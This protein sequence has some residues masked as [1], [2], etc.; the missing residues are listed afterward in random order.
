MWQYS[1]VIST[2]CPAFVQKDPH[3]LGFHDHLAGGRI[4]QLH[5]PWHCGQL[6]PIPVIEGPPIP[7]HPG[8]MRPA[9]VVQV[10]G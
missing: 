5:D 10:H 4:D 1:G 3:D 7:P 8:D 6:K 2:R 9:S